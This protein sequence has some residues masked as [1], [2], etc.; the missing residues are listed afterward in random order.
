MKHS[1]ILPLES[2]DHKQKDLAVFS[3]S[4]KKV[5]KFDAAVYPVERTE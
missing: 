2:D 4:V 1:T 3:R 5:L